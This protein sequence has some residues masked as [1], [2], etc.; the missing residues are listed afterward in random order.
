MLLYILLIIIAIGV[1]LA[2]EAGQ[3]L[4]GFLLCVGAVCLVAY[5][6][7]YAVIF[8]I[9]LWQNYSPLL[10]LKSVRPEY[11]WILG[12]IIGAIFI[13]AT[14]YKALYPLGYDKNRQLWTGKLKKHT[15]HDKEEK[16]REDKN[17]GVSV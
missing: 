12:V 5:V 8:I 2:S 7:F 4:L 3:K 6:G 13:I 1:L 15:I 10:R 9:A 16:S 17:Q 11:D 14:L